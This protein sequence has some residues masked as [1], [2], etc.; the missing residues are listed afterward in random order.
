MPQPRPLRIGEGSTCS[1]LVK[2]LRPS[3]NVAAAIL[4]PTANQRVDDLVA[5]RH[6]VTTRLGR[7]YD[8][9]FFTSPS[10]PGIELSAA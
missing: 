8:T 6:A 9:I 5:T 3:R 2:K 7:S 1:V 10:I 4:N